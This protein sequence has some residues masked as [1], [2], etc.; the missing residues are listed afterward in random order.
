MRSAGSP[1]RHTSFTVIWTATV[2]SNI[3]WWMYSAASGWLMTS[4]NPSPLVVSLVQVA[5]SLPMFLLALPAG[6]IGDIVDRRKFL[7]VGELA[8]SV[9]AAAFAALVWLQLVTTGSLLFFTFLVG[10]GA[11]ITAPAWQSVV[12]QLVPK[13]D[14]APAVAANSVGVNISRAIGPALGG[15]LTAAYGI[16]APFWIN[17]VGNLSVVAALLWWRQPIRDRPQLP[18]EHFTNAIRTGLRYARYNTPL[19][20]TLA[21]TTG[22]FL[23]ASAY[24]ALLPLVA[25]SQIAGGPEI[26]GILLG[27]IGG[28]AIGGAFALRRLNAALGPDRLV[29]VGTLATALTLALFALARDIGLAVTASLIAGA[30]WI[31]VLSTLNVSAQVALPDWV[32][33]RGLAIFVTVFYGAMTIGSAIWGELASVA[34]LPVAHVTA[35]A[36]ALIAIPLPWRWELHTG[37]GL[38]LSPS[39][40][41]STPI[42]MRDIG[43]DRG[44]V[45]IMVEYD[46]E[47]EHRAPFLN[48]LG[49][50]ARERLR[51]GAHD[52]GVFEDP[53]HGGRFVETFQTDSWLE[54]LRGHAR[55]TGSDRALQTAVNHFQRDG[56]PK[57][58]HLI[59]AGATAPRKDTT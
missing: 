29:A 52:W 43:H 28:G 6:A 22:F 13:P 15:A 7:L 24:W 8:T 51:N 49:K 27:A 1:F 44:P 48:A 50:L 58:T 57:I 19:R 9:F 5:S 42:M 32:R 47:P 26:Y 55:M 21:R 11:A 40:D 53:A 33:G 35:A 59:A 10:A 39:M 20:A 2:I 25:R 23:F 16:A 37:A 54:Y 45:L 18:P 12:P 56:A 46:I 30:S 31:A 17:A 4:L 3:G 36:G 38:D 14:L 41:C 34:G